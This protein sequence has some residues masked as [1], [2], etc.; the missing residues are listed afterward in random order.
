MKRT[1][2]M[3]FIIFIMIGTASAYGRCPSLDGQT[4]RNPGYEITFMADPWGPGQSG[5]LYITDYNGGE[6][7]CEYVTRDRCLYHVFCGD[8]VM[9]LYWVDGNLLLLDRAPF[10]KS[11]P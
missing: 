7:M 8:A 2:I 4:Y 9:Y 3:L 6:S 1:M 5:T 11:D 10:E